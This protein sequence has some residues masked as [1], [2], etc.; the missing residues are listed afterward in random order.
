[1]T[2]SDWNW[3]VLPMMFA[4]CLGLGGSLTA[5]Q[6]TGY[7]PNLDLGKHRVGFRSEIVRDRSRVYQ[8]EFDDGA[9]Y[10]VDQKR[11]RPILVNW[12]YPAQATGQR[13]PMSYGAYFELHS[14]QPQTQIWADRL[15]AY[16]MNT[17]CREIFGKPTGELD[18]EETDAWRTLL[19]SPTHCR[20]EAAPQKGEFPLV[21]YH[22][23]AAS[24][25]E[26]NAA[27]CEFLASHGFVVIGSAF[28][29]RD[30]S[31]LNIDGR[32]GSVRDLAWLVQQAVSSGGNVNWS[33]IYFVGH[34]AGAQAILRAIARPD[35]PADAVVLLDSTLDYYGTNV[36]T[37][38][39]LSKQMIESAANVNLPMLVTASPGAAFELCDALTQADRTYHTIP[40]LDH[41]EFIAQGLVRQ[42]V[43]SQLS[44]QL[45]R[46]DQAE[47][48]SKEHHYRQLCE[49]IRS[50]LQSGGQRQTTDLNAGPAE[51]GAAHD[52]RSNGAVQ[53]VLPGT[54]PTA[55]YTNLD[56]PPYPR[57]IRSA[58]A[59][60]GVEAITRLLEAK[61]K[62]HA[63]NPVYG[64]QMLFG[65]LLFELGADGRIA[66]A[67]RLHQCCS[68][69]D[70]DALSTLRFLAF[71]SRL[72]GKDDL[73]AEYLQLALKIS[74]DDQKS[75][76]K[77]DELRK[78][79]G[80]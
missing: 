57:E 22:S 45:R 26:D 47:A 62:T 69:L 79:P 29:R 23:G 41:N 8:I 54:G 48:D 46:G 42:N 49:T 78:S 75:R 7:I 80:K 58:I 77:L 39:E 65:S 73:A 1:M 72:Q 25:Y 34:S 43:L 19:D 11:P 30:G 60:H 18:A 21:V 28:Q 59:S 33:R 37:F 35:C 15:A 53:V 70:I 64:N 32:D 74:P 44:Q 38:A 55:N 3:N 5:Q 14:D 40:E 68:T 9:N 36:P 4:V 2:G 6:S 16:A 13:K 76:E 24:S 31:S 61:M 66:E 20:R 71:M 51:D 10:G 67:Q 50:F 27:F 56:R 52:S 12:W 63:D 17:A